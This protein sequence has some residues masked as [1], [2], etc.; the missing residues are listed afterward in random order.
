MYLSGDYEYADLGEDP[1]EWLIDGGLNHLPESSLSSA[2]MFP[3]FHSDDLSNDIHLLPQSVHLT[4]S[5]IDSSVLNMVDPKVTVQSL[6][7]SESS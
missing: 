4:A 2:P 7:L 3:E 1:L 5:E 6:F